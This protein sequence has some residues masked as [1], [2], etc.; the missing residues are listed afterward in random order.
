MKKYQPLIFLFLFVPFIS[1]A[2][3]GKKLGG[4]LGG[5]N[6]EAKGG[7]LSEK[8][9]IS[10]LKEALAQ[11][12]KKGATQASSP[13]GFLKNEVIKLLLP[14]EL[15]RAESTLRKMGLGPEVDKFIVSLNRAAEGAAK[16]SVPI[17]ANAVTS[18]SI[19]D[20]LSILNGADTAATS[21]LKQK[22]NTQ[23]Y[24]AFSPVVK[25]TLDKNH[26]S[27][28]YTDLANAYNKVPLVKKINPDLI[29]YA[30]QKT[31]DGLFHLVGEEEKKIRKDPVARVTQTLKKVFGQG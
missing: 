13:D 3:L 24:K 30:T 17:F 22:T 19:T 5:E 15:Q 11:G 20:A 23:L 16:E 10:G 4:L 1:H 21:Y 9:I 2:Q 12:I 7:G 31:M 8:E 18:M 6:S 29:Q 27:R 25:N 28:Y 14:P 26:V